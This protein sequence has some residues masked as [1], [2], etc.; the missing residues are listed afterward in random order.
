MKHAA[1]PAVDAPSP[2]VL[3]GK[4]EHGLYVVVAMVFIAAAFLTLRMARTMADGMPMPGGWTMS[5]TWMGMGGAWWTQ[6]AAFSWMWLSMMVAMMLPSALPMLRLFLRLCRWR[7]EPH[8]AL[9]SGL[10]A[11]GYF[12]VWSGFGLVAWMVGTAVAH[13]AMLSER[14][15]HAVPLMGAVALMVA[16]AYQ[17]T[18]VKMACLEHCR[19]PLTFVAQHARTDWR[20]AVAFGLHHGGFCLACCWALMLIQ[21]ALGIMSLSVMIGVA[22]IIALEKLLPHGRWIARATGLLAI[23]IGAVQLTQRIV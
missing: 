9:L 21:L 12:L 10:V 17:L 1:H 15:S 19:D 8:P 23:G 18:P 5:M 14:V 3:R 13:A 22:A 20:G 2:P 11:G 4:S 6:A 7:G 16:G